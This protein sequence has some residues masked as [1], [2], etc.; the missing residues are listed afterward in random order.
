MAAS[1]PGFIYVSKMEILVVGLLYDAGVL[2][3]PALQYG[4]SA[5]AL[6]KAAARLEDGSPASPAGELNDAIVRE[7]ETANQ[8]N[9]QGAADTDV[10]AE[11]GQVKKW[12]RELFTG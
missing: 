9:S 1:R 12:A 4:T 6:V 7:V 11:E 2:L 3:S 5:T 10:P 8:S